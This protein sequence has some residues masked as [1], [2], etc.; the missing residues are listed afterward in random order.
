MADAVTHP[1]RQEL[2]AFGLGKLPEVKAVAVASHVE[3]CT[4]CRQA[5]ENLPPDSFIGKVRAAKPGGSSYPSG[6]SAAGTG[7]SSS[8]KQAEILSAPPADLPPELA[9][10]EKYRF[11]RELGR[12]G[13]GIVYEAEQILMDR[14]VAIKVINSSLLDHPEALARFLGEVKASARLDHPNI[15]RAYDADRVDK[16]H[17]LVM[18]FVD[19]LS[20]AELVQLRQEP[21]PVSFACHFI[22]Q[23]AKGLHHAFERGMVHR[24]IKPGNLMVTPRGRLKILDFGLARWHSEKGKG[25]GLTG[26]HAFMGTPEYVSPE[27]A[28]DARTA[29]IRADIYSLGCTLYFLLTGQPPFVADT[30]LKVLLAQI[31]KEPPKL[32]ELRPDVPVELSALA[33]KLLAKD[34]ARRCQQPLEVAEALKPFIRPD[35]TLSLP[36]RTVP[37]PSGAS[38]AKGTM[39]RADTSKLQEPRQESLLKASAKEVL[40]WAEHPPEV[41]VDQ[42]GRDALLSQLEAL[43]NGPDVPRNVKKVCAAAKSMPVASY[44]R[45]QGIVGVATCLFLLGLAGLW[46]SGVLKVKTPYG[47]IE[48]RLVPRDAEV[49]VDGATATVTWG[50]DGRSAEIRVK[51]GTRQ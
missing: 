2:I 38:P 42:K 15:V 4:A 12:G 27:Q 7:G 16:L 14:K 31:E 3:T 32:H 44:K 8:G 25:R 51:P 11:V 28:T 26:L 45:W 49:L 17:L 40:D 6:L 5:L 43:A 39:I 48:L 33:A 46:A 34:P 47:T 50:S 36:G 35:S 20:L 37:S 29:D 10:S 30:E 19:G 21:L 1:D 22:R 9:N 13:M 18:E 24:D 41:R 23:A